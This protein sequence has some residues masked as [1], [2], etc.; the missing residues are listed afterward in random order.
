MSDITGFKSLAKNIA[1]GWFA[2]I[3]V[4]ISGFIM[5]RL[6]SDNLGPNLLG[7]WDLGWAT[8]RYLNIVNVGVGPAIGRNVAF[9]RARDDNSML[10]QVISVS[11]IWQA[12]IAVMIFIVGMNFVPYVVEWSHFSSEEGA[13]ASD[14]L[15]VFIT[16]ISVQMFALPGGGILSGSHRWDIQHTIN[17]MDDLFVTLALFTIIML[18]GSLFELSL[19]VL[20]VAVCIA[21]LRMYFALRECKGLS[22]SYR[23]WKFKLVM[24]MIRFGAKSTLWNVPNILLFQSMAF[25][26]AGYAGPAVLAVFNRGVALVRFG[27]QIVRKTMMMIMPIASSLQGLDRNEEAKDLIVEMGRYSTSFYLPMA[28]VLLGFGDYILLVWMGEDYANWTMLAALVL[29][30][31]LP[32]GQLGSY[33]IVQGMDAHG[34]VALHACAVAIVLLCI[35]APMVQYVG[36]TATNA[37]IFAGFIWTASYSFVLPLFLKKHYDISLSKYI[38]GLILRP[39]A[40]CLPLM[41]FILLTRFFIE[42]NQLLIAAVVF[43]IGGVCTLF[44]YW[45]FVLHQKVRQ[46]LLDKTGIGEKL[47]LKTQ[48]GTGSE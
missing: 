30:S 31:I 32:I 2:Q 44:V 43:A 5:P 18:G 4:M 13:L 12:I 38:N 8:S 23:H 45:R 35:F 25:L 21:I 3:I 22:L 40:A 6:I 10:E 26:I 24:K 19:A 15:M 39:V 1:V 41:G 17:G 33:Y 27:E 29:G 46:T 20:F 28:L 48:G 47:A 7:I 34:R 9:Y 37:A 11:F 16:I 36:W 42:R 14:V